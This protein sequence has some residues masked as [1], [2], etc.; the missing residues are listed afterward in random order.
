M[1]APTVALSCSTERGCQV[2][3]RGDGHAGNP[4]CQLRTYRHAVAAALPQVI[5]LDGRQLSAERSAAVTP[6]GSKGAVALQ[7]LAAMQLQA[8]QQVCSMSSPPFPV[9]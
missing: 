6:G 4:L 2:S 1:N 8:F 3:D 7:H 9:R 5:A